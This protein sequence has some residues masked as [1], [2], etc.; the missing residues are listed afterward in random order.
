MPCMILFVASGTLVI[1][2]AMMA[3]HIAPGLLRHDQVAY[4]LGA[5]STFL[6]GKSKGSCLATGKAIN[7]IKWY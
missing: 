1:E 2:A 7:Q 6:V 5:A 3:A 4:S